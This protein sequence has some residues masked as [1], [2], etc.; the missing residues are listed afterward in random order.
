MLSIW[1]SSTD[2]I[3]GSST[4]GYI[5]FD[6]AK[7]AGALITDADNKWEAETPLVCI[8]YEG[9]KKRYYIKRFLLDNNDSI[10][11]FYTLEKQNSHIEYIITQIGAEVI[12]TYPEG[13]AKTLKKIAI[14]VDDF[15]KVMGIKAKGNQL[16]NREISDI[17]YTSGVDEVLNG[18]TVATNGA[19][20]FAPGTTGYNVETTDKVVVKVEIGLI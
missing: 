10:Q 19:V 3:S 1:I 2:S 12:L 17:A 16:I 7:A 14:K 11:K 6:I 20:T 5:N 8:Y 9:D 18:P 13:R 4:S 15:V